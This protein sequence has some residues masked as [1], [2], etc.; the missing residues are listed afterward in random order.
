MVIQGLAVRRDNIVLLFE[1]IDCA[2]SRIR[3]LAKLSQALLQPV[4]CQPIRLIFCFELVINIGVCNRIRDFSGSVGACITV[5]N[6]NDAASTSG[7]LDTETGFEFIYG[8]A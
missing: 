5:T 2:L 7:V 1:G 6:C 4:R 3:L 8:L